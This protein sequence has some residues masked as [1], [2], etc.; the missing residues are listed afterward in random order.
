MKSIRGQI[1][2][3]GIDFA[4][5]ARVPGLG[6]RFKQGGIELARQA[7]APG[8]GRNHNPVDI[9]KPVITRL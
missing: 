6:G 8:M 1:G 5:Y 3:I 2:R 9:D 7:P 4:D